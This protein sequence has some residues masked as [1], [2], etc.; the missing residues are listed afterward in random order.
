MENRIEISIQSLT[1]ILLNVK[2]IYLDLIK[3]LHLEKGLLLEPIPDKIALNNQVKD[4]LIQQLEKL[5]TE[6]IDVCH[7]LGVVFKIPDSPPRLDALIKHLNDSQ[8][9]NLIQIRN[10]LNQLFDEVVMLNRD[11][12]IY[13][14]SGLKA[15]TGAVD[16]LKESISGQKTYERKGYFKDAAQA[17]HLVSKEA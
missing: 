16:H 10:E 1:N 12:Q 5:E 8:S 2:N 14:E 9:N 15:L 4:V 7:D 3:V 13:A 17:G 6:R 11:N